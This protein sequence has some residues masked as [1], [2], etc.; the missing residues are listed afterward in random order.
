M[1]SFKPLKIDDFFTRTRFKEMVHLLQFAGGKRVNS[2]FVSG[3]TNRIDIG[4]TF[5]KFKIPK[6]LPAWLL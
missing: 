1:N 4:F 2:L 5:A 6:L 3:K